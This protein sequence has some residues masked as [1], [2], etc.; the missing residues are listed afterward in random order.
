MLPAIPEFRI[1]GKIGEHEVTSLLLT[2]S[3]VMIPKLDVGIDFYCEL[4]ENSSPCGKFF[5]VQAKATEKFDEIWSGYIDKK[6]IALWL[7]QIFPVFLL[8]FEQSSQKF[9]WL[10]VEKN[11]KE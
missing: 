11:R 8:L 7:N 1:R 2:F 5:C 4:S 9:Y 10:S 3:N 6:T